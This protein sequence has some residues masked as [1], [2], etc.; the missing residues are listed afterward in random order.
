MRI[1]LI[2]FDE[3][4]EAVYER[5]VVE[6]VVGVYGMRDA[7]VEAAAASFGDHG[8]AEI[9]RT[10]ATLAQQEEAIATVLVGGS[11]NLLACL[12]IE[13]TVKVIVQVA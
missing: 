7:V 1:E 9:V 2:V 5:T 10:S 12:T 4:V 3:L 8:Q 13:I 11:Q 6:H